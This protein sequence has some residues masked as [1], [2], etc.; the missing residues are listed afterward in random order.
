[1]VPKRLLSDNGPHFAGNSS[2]A[3]S[4]LQGAHPI[5]ASSYH[6][7]TNGETELRAEPA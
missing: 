3:I 5:F 1:G 2:A 4:N 7:S 6:P